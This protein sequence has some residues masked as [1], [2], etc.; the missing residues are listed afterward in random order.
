MDRPRVL[1]VDDDDELRTQ[2]RWALNSRYEVL[3]A[4]DRASALDVLK[5]EQPGVVT[6][7]L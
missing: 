2:M 5:R 4:E 6:L 7:D 3:Q 1:I